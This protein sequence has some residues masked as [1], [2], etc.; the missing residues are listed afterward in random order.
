MHLAEMNLRDWIVTL[1][2]SLR[3]LLFKSVTNYFS[4]KRIT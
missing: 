4:I 1:I 3:Q 2:A